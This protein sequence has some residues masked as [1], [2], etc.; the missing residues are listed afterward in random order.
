MGDVIPLL[1]IMK[2]KN[3][4]IT[5]KYFGIKLDAQYYHVIHERVTLIIIELFNDHIK[6]MPSLVSM[7]KG[8]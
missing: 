2:T 3:N 7:M 4:V 5:E 1:I 6:T 8:F